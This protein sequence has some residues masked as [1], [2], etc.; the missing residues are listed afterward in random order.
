M[1]LT[2][3]LLFT[4]ACREGS[5]EFIIEIFRDGSCILYDETV[6]RQLCHAGKVGQAILIEEIKAD[7]PSPERDRKTE[8]GIRFIIDS[9]QLSLIR[10]AREEFEQ[11]DDVPVDLEREINSGFEPIFLKKV[12]PFLSGPLADIG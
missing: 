6:R 5:R 11:T 10:R 7:E 3:E 12:I 8:F 4:W 9:G 1:A 2:D